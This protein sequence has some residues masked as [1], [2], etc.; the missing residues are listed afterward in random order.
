[1]NIEAISELEAKLESDPELFVKLQELTTPRM[2]KYIPHQPTV[3]QSA[4]LLLDGKEAFYGGAAG[5]GK[6]DALLMAALQYVDIPGYA[7]IIFRKTF[8]DLSLPG[9]L[10]ERAH[11]WLGPTDAKWIERDKTWT[12]PSGAT[13]TFGFIEH[14][15]DKY[16]YQSS[17][18]QFVGF[19]EVSQ[20]TESSVLYLFSRLRKLVNCDIPLR[21]R[22]ASNPG[23][24]G[25]KWVKARYV[26]NS[27]RNSR[28]FIS[29][30]IQDNPYLDQMTYRESLAELPPDIRK[31]LEEGDWSDPYPEGAYYAKQ[32]E[33]ARKEGRI[34]SVPYDSRVLVDTWWDIGVGDANSIWFTQSV[35]KEIHVIDFLESEGE[36]VGY[37]IRELKNKPY[38]YGDHYAPHDI[39]VREYGS[40]LT[41]K[42]QAESLGLR[43]RVVPKQSIDDG[44]NAARAIFGMCWFDEKKCVDGLN[45]LANYHKVWDAKAG[46]YK[47]MPAHDWSSHAAD[48]WRTF[49]LGYNQRR[50]NIGQ[51]RKTQAKTEFSI[52]GVS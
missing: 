43:F 44:I 1:M 21:L 39:E 48:A 12:F 15:K 45:A 10:M 34:T 4:F 26:T 31:Q 20:F 2:T 11:E 17:E 38:V 9:A 37:Y 5:G 50:K 28:I 22:S 32:L 3:K 16:N 23:G 36:G 46:E 18:F 24:V 13:L 40:G 27:N 52:F 42:E 35:G 33:A 14:E 51:Q 7:A 47:N 25:H 30:K 8:R 6:S 49:A 41:R 29:A 19:D